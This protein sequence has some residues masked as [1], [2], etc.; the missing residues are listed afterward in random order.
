MRNIEVKYELTDRTTAERLCR[1]QGAQRLGVLDQTD[2]Y[3]RVPHGHLKRRVCMGKPIEWIV[4]ERTVS[5]NASSSEYEIYSEKDAKEA[6]SSKELC[7]WVEVKKTRTLYMKG[8]VRIH[9]DRVEGLGDY[10]EF[11]ALVD[12]RQN[13][14][15]ARQA[16][17]DLLSAFESVMGLRLIDSYSDL[18]A[19][20]QL[21]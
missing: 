10:L 2:T 5:G 13:E 12:D 15:E 16:L 4:Y 1:D 7:V 17:Y 14:M 9:L 11:E 3:Y 20:K 18:L 21:K 19:I 8:L 6:L